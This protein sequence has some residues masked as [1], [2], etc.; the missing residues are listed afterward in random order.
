MLKKILL[1]E[2]EKF[3]DPVQLLLLMLSRYARAV[4]K[5]DPP[6]GRGGLHKIIWTVKLLLLARFSSLAICVVG[7]GGEPL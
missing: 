5:E 7:E 4:G 2:E 6:A 1:Q 3:C